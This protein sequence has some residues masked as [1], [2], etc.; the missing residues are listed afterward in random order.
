MQKFVNNN[1]NNNMNTSKKQNKMQ[2]IS[3]K[4][5]RESKLFV[6]CVSEN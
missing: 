3:L 2:E 5:T 1:N 6:G 4:S